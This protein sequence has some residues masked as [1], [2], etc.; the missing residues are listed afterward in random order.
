LTRNLGKSEFAH[1]TLPVDMQQR[2]F[3]RSLCRDGVHHI[4]RE[5][6]L[7][8]VLEGYRLQRPA[9]ILHRQAEIL[10]HHRA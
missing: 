7:I 6:E 9:L 4:E 10:V 1:I 5:V 3:I 2:E 8:L